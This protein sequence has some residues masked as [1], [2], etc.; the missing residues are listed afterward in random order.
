MAESVADAKHSV[1]RLT[2]E[3]REM[4]IFLC[5]PTLC[6]Y[7]I[8][9]FSFQLLP[10]EEWYIFFLLKWILY[11]WYWKRCHSGIS[12]EV[13]VSVMNIFAV[14][15]SSLQSLCTSSRL[16]L[17]PY[18]ILFWNLSGRVQKVSVFCKLPASETCRPKSNNAST[19]SISSN[20]QCILIWGEPQ[21]RHN[22]L[23]NAA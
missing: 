4:F 5:S 13:K 1:Y 21:H 14:P 8:S 9:F 23:C 12:I 3:M 18:C 16:V 22:P 20:Y 11:N 6:R 10:G 15:S 19:K 7:S 2:D 17:F